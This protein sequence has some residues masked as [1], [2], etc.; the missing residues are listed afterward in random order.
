MAEA[1]LREFAENRYDT[2]IYRRCGR[3]G[4]K[5]PTISLGAWETL[6][7]YRASRDS[8]RT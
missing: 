8:K 2:M 1:T 5:L 4:L 7:G 3:S 6:G